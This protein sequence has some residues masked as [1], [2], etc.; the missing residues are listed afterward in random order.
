MTPQKT[1]PVAHRVA[2]PARLLA[3]NCHLSLRVAT[4]GSTL[5]LAIL[6]SAIFNLQTSILYS[7]F[8]ILRQRATVGR[9]RLDCLCHIVSPFL[10]WT[11]LLARM[12]HA[13]S[14]DSLRRRKACDSQSSRTAS[15]WWPGQYGRLIRALHWS[16][17]ID[18]ST[19]FVATST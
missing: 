9:P 1:A 2:V 15:R 3:S 11:R 17:L 14:K 18:C 12:N 8:S 4:P 19:L 10:E 7:L 13:R 6:Q 5:L 16:S